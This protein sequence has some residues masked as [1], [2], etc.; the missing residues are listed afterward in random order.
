[1]KSPY[2]KIKTFIKEI[3]NLRI[4]AQVPWRKEKDVRKILVG[5]LLLIRTKYEQAATVYK[6]FWRSFPDGYVSSK[7]KQKALEILMKAGLKHRAE[8]ILK[9]LEYLNQHGKDLNEFSFDDLKKIPYVSDYVASA[10]LF[11]SGKSNFLYPDSN[12]IRIFD[13]YFGIKGKDKTH[14]SQKQLKLLKIMIKNIK[15]EKKKRKFTI[16]LL[17][18]GLF[19][20][21]PKPNCSICP[22]SNY[23]CYVLKYE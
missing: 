6:E 19:I 17:D 4:N 8:G 3:L 15:K 1:M 2:R 23:C 10:V 22:L 13:R 7:D 14:P 20:C 18:F 11:L 12:I 21:R 16:N 5:E 9:A